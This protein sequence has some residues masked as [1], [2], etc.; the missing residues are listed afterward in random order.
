MG[1]KRVINT[2]HSEIFECYKNKCITFD[3]RLEIEIGYDGYDKT[4]A[5]VNNSIPVVIDWGEPSCFACGR[6]TGVQIEN[7]DDNIKKLWDDKKVKSNLQRAHIIP[8]ALGGTDSP[9]NLFC[10]CAR[11]HRDSPDTIYPKEFFKWVYQRRKDGT[12]EQRTFTKAVEKCKEE[13][14]NPVFINVDKT[15][16]DN[17]KTMNTHGSIMSESSYIASLVGDAT[18]AQ[19]KINKAITSFLLAKNDAEQQNAIFDLRN[20]VLSNKNIL[21]YLKSERKDELLNEKWG[22]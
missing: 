14:V 13:N 12:V 15:F 6:W 17:F 2:R 18:E 10:L 3:G 4:K 16:N 5:N 1:A 22:L 19:D 8:A 20:Y 11:C 7:N 21:N 9:E